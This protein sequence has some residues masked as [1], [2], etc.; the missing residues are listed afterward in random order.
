MSRVGRKPI[1]VPQGVDIKI[2][3][4]TITVSKN[5]QS[6]VQ[7]IHPSIKI[8]YNPEQQVIQV[9]R[10]TNNKLHRSLHGLFR[11][12]VSNMVVGLTEGFKKH[13]EIVG[14]GYRAELKGKNL[15]LSLGYSHSILFKPPE[16]IEIVLEN[17]TNIIVKGFDKQLVGQVSAKIRSFRPP[18]PYKGKGIKYKDEFIKRKAGKTAA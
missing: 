10:P 2:E 5:Q 18:E 6:L 12:L 3:K 7:T 9:N 16:G 11:S 4:N 8:E 15:M 17:P 1:E 14:V 13:L